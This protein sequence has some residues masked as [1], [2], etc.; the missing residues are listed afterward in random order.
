MQHKE[1]IHLCDYGCGRKAIKKFGNGKWCCSETYKSCP[2]ITKKA[3]L[4]IIGYKPIKIPFDNIN[5]K[6]CDYGCG[7]IAKFIIKFKKC[8]KLCCSENYSLCKSN[9]KTW[10]KGLTDDTDERVKRSHQNKKRYKKLDTFLKKH[11]EFLKYEIIEEDKE[12]KQYIVKCSKCENKFI[13]KYRQ[14]EYRIFMINNGNINKGKFICK[15]CKPEVEYKLTEYERYQQK[16][17]KQTEKMIR[18]YKDKIVNIDLRGRKHGYQIDHKYSVL[19]GFKNNIDPYIVSH[20]KNL[21]ILK[22]NDNTRK[23]DKCSI[24]LEELIEEIKKFEATN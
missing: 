24:T 10:N 11:K 18:K 2:E 9:I 14:L 21:E 23:L 8:E 20:V 17:Y 22:D 7:E 12:T 4:K 5:N 6:L 15:E 19:E 3:T 16:V 1:E 13:P